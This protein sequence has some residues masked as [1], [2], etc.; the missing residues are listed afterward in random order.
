MW[1]RGVFADV[2]QKFWSANQFAIDSW[3]TSRSLDRM[4]YLAHLSHLQVE[5]GWFSSNWAHG[6][7]QLCCF[8]LDTLLF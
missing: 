8:S 4:Q 3:L 5:I 1:M 7:C 2:S 6:E